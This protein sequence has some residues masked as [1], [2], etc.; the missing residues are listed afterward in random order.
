MLGRVTRRAF[1]FKALHDHM[2]ER[3]KNLFSNM[4]RNRKVERS[5]RLNSNAA[6]KASLRLF[7]S[8]QVKN[9]IL[10]SRL[11]T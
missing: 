9:D 6:A 7:R 11:R 3:Q 8:E 5:S 1:S 10:F 2:K 4:E